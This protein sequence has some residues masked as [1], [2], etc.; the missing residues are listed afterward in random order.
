MYR[1]PLPSPSH[2]L[3]IVYWKRCFYNRLSESEVRQFVIESLESI[4][5]TLLAL[6]Q[7]LASSA[8]TTGPKLLSFTGTDDAW[9]RG[10]RTCCRRI[11][12]KPVRSFSIALSMVEKKSAAA[13]TQFVPLG[14]RTLFR[15]LFPR[16]LFNGDAVP[17]LSHDR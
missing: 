15:C 14:D 7:R 4:V 12:G 17:P 8:S 6:Q 13:G 10:F 2:Q 16:A 3:I 11:I 9:Y 5:F 1:N